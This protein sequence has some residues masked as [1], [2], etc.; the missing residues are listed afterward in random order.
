MTKMTKILKSV[1]L[2]ALVLAMTT[3]FAY[4]AKALNDT[5]R[6][7]ITDSC[8]QTD[9]PGFSDFPE[10]LAT[11]GFSLQV[12]D[13]FEGTLHF[14]KNGTATLVASGRYALPGIP[15]QPVGTFTTVCQYTST[16]NPDGSFALAGYC[17]SEVL[18]GIG[19]G[20]RNRNETLH[21]KVV[22]HKDF[23]LLSSTG[24]E[25]ATLTIVNRDPPVSFF[26]ICQLHGFGVKDKSGD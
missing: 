14:H 13:T 1:V 26:R 18:S 8:Q 22:S 7:V 25:V 20:E 19:L 10:L 11:N 2:S 16:A 12:L 9:E 15:F 5:Y 21:L 3:Q 6:V 23:I 24:V 17:D 4:A